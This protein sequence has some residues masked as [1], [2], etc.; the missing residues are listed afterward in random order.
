[1]KRPNKNFGTQNHYGPLF[2]QCKDNLGK[3]IL[4]SR[5]R[6]GDLVDTKTASYFGGREDKATAILGPKCWHTVRL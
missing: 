4:L 5:K 2:Q 1:M 3:G 6:G